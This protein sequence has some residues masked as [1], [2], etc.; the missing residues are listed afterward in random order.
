MI[1]NNTKNFKYLIGEYT[2]KLLKLRELSLIKKL[3]VEYDVVYSLG[4]LFNL[5]DKMMLSDY[6]SLLNHQEAEVFVHRFINNNL[7]IQHI[8]YKIK[9]L[10]LILEV[11]TESNRNDIV[12]LI[13]N[14][15]DIQ[16]KHTHQQLN[17]LLSQ[18]NL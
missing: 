8:G 13:K 9:Y 14:W 11:A 5:N 7:G 10:N 4:T 16:A 12:I 18:L 1:I 6:I 17:Q 2:P 15:Y 3:N